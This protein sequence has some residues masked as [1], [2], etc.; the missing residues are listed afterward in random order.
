M[1]GAAKKQVSMLSLVRRH[2]QLT[3][4]LAA[5]C[6]ARAPA[7][8]AP[9][10]KVEEWTLPDGR[11]AR[12]VRDVENPA[13]PSE[14][15]VPVPWPSSPPALLPGS[16]STAPASCPSTAEVP[17]PA[18]FTAL[19][20]ALA[21]AGADDVEAVA[22][23]NG[24]AR[25]RQLR[26]SG[27]V[28]RWQLR[29]WVSGGWVAAVDWEFDPGLKR[30]TTVSRYDLVAPLDRFGE[31]ARDEVHHKRFVTLARGAPRVSDFTHYRGEPALYQRGPPPKRISSDRAP[32][33]CRADGSN[34]CDS[35]EWEWHAAFEA[36]TAY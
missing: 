30:P 24:C 1:R 14:K 34:H 36:G 21:A 23:K 18:Q 6:P 8:A 35:L 4:L 10:E 16:G 17:T 13:P 7:P 5:A 26:A 3:L 20:D 22:L 15:F 2:L 29:R 27:F 25:L 12:G 28:A 19:L 33:V 9:A 32:I 11:L 31:W